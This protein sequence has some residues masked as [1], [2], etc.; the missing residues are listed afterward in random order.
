M[1]QVGDAVRQDSRL[2][3]PGP[4][5]HEQGPEFVD[6]GVELIGVQT[7]GERRRASPAA[8]ERARVDVVDLELAGRVGVGPIGRMGDVGEEFVVGH[9]DV[10][11]TDGL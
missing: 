1:D 7:F 3:R 5:H 10:H 4:G 6:D 8:T 11:S 9:G 2:A